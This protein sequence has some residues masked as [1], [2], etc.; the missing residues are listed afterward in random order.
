[1]ETLGTPESDAPVHIV[2]A[3]SEH[4]GLRLEGEGRWIEI[5]FWIDDSDP[6]LNPMAAK[7]APLLSPAHDFLDGELRAAWSADPDGNQVWFVQ[8]NVETV[9]YRARKRGLR[10]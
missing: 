5:V 7:G 8:R 9:V 4:H 6:A 2:E 1:M 10:S 3:A